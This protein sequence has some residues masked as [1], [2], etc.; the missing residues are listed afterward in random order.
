MAADHSEFTITDGESKRISV[1][2]VWLSIMVVFIHSYDSSINFVGETVALDVPVWLDATKY[3]ISQAISQSAVP[4]FFFLSAF[5]LYRKPFSWKQ[6]ICKKA[7]S[8]LVPYFILNTFWILVFFVGQHIPSLSPYFSQP[9]NIVANWSIGDWFARFFGSP[10]NMYP[11]LYPLW[12]IRDLFV[13]NLL[14][15]PFEWFVKKAGPWS[16][17]V[18]LA[19]WL[20]LDSTHL[21]FLNIPSLC[22]WGIGCY[23]AVRRIS[24]S[25]LDQ[26]NKTALV[27][28]CLLII[29]FLLRN[30]A[31]IEF[32]FFYRL[33]LLVGV[34]FWYTFT[35]KIN[36]ESRRNAL[37]FVSKYSFCI[38]LFHEMNLTILRKILTKLVPQTP[39]FALILYFGVTMLIVFLCVLLSW[40]LEKYMP[41]FYRVI[42]GGRSR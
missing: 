10:S 33:C 35:T 9:K 5:F 41:K 22:F 37:L 11:L 40:F 1:L 8:L 2:K 30:S 6:N 21:F 27:Y 17:A 4:A 42:S 19:V 13:L 34:Y 12:F 31:G 28:P 38:F 16:L 3:I 14:A 24:V 39:I 18:F 36:R 26:Y 23:F 7:Q 15:P 32:R 20:L 25:S 29:V